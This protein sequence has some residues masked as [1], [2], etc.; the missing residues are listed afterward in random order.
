MS[1][2]IFVAVDCPYDTSRLG[3]E[4]LIRSYDTAASW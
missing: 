2:C 3:L 4:R 1:V